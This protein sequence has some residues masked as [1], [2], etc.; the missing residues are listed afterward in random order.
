MRPVA[1]RPQAQLWTVGAVLGCTGSSAAQAVGSEENIHV[2]FRERIDEA[3][4][5]IPAPAFTSHGY[6]GRFAGVA[7]FLC[8]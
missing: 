7:S 8:D 3:V 4:E 6:L 2:E 1:E 5:W